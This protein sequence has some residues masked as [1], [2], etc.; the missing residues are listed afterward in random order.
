MVQEANLFSIPLTV[1]VDESSTDF[2]HWTVSNF[3]YCTQ[4]RTPTLKSHGLRYQ[5]SRNTLW[6]NEVMQRDRCHA[7]SLCHGGCA[8]KGIQQW[9]SQ[10]L[11]LP[12]VGHAR[13]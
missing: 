10:I 1:Q 12:R 13:L 5:C 3:V 6:S 4:A 7:G 11:Q 2:T 9:G 8:A